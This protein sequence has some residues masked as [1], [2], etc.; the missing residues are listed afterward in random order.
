MTAINRIPHLHSLFSAD[1]RNYVQL[2]GG[3]LAVNRKRNAQVI[4]TSCS[5]THTVTLPFSASTITTF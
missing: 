2:A 3:V 4:L 1:I 5:R